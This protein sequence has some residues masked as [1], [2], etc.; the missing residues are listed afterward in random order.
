MRLRCKK[1][2]V[3]FLIPNDNSLGLLGPD[4][5]FSAEAA[6]NYIKRTHSQK[7]KYYKTI[8]DCFKAL[9]QNRVSRIIVPLINSTIGEIQETTENI[10]GCKI[11]EEEKLTINLHLAGNAANQIYTKKEVAKQCKTRLQNERT[12]YV[13]STA[14]A[15]IEAKNNQQAAI[16]SRRAAEIYNLDILE[17]NIQDRKDNYTKFVVLSL[18]PT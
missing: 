14:A 1:T 10:K 4:G 8:S 12:I 5:T 9:K 18:L 6:H 3:V 13:N 7:I 16:I 11:T 17:E 2:L 15:A